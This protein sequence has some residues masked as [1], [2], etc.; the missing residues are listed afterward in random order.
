MDEIYVLEQKI[1]SLKECRHSSKPEYLKR[2]EYFEKEL[3]NIGNYNLFLDDERHPIRSIEYLRKINGFGELYLLKD[4]VLVTTLDEFSDII[5]TRGLPERISFD[6]DLG[7]I[8]A[9]KDKNKK[10]KQRKNRVLQPSG[11]D[12]AKWLTDYC[13]DNKIFLSSEIKVHSANPVGAENIRA[14]FNT[15][16][17]I[18]ATVRCYYD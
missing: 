6:H 1:K 13:I 2:I 12:C 15:F 10:R 7:E 14:I 5:K 9:D 16:M 4:W 8:I 18:Y 3:D 17:K 11:M